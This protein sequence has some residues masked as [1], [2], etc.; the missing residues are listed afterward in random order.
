MIFTFAARLS[1]LSLPALLA[2]K[3]P[4]LRPTGRLEHRTR[5]H[6]PEL[7]PTAPSATRFRVASPSIFAFRCL[8]QPFVAHTCSSLDS[9]PAIARHH[10]PILPDM[11]HSLWTSMTN[12]S[13]PAAGIVSPS[14][15]TGCVLRLI[16]F[17]LNHVP[18][19]FHP[20]V[21][22]PLGHVHIEP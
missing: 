3:L 4:S 10:A 19:S 16:P 8:P 2:S 1:A 5:A 12:T 21:T 11:D 17:H 22:L 15:L 7:L 14:T 13:T 6:K 9:L 18:Q 20:F